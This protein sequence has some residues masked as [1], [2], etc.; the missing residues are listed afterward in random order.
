MIIKIENQ[1][2]NGVMFDTGDSHT[3]DEYYP[4]ETLAGMMA[5]G[6]TLFAGGK[7]VTKKMLKELFA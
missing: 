3:L 4:Y 6:Y 7:K 1:D 5:C 2:G